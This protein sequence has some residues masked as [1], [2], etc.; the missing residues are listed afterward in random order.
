MSETKQVELPHGETAWT[1]KGD[2]SPDEGM[3]CPTCGAE[4]D[5]WSRQ[6]EDDFWECGMCGNIEWVYRKKVA[7]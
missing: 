2:I 1:F 7:G 4:A 3:V 5:N 6:M